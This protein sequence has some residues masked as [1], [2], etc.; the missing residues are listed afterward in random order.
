MVLSELAANAAVEALAGR[1]DGGSLRL[2]AGPQPAAPEDEPPG[3]LLAELRFAV[4]AFGPARSG[5]VTAHALAPERDA[6]AA[7]VA[8]WFRCLTASG[9]AVLDGTA[10]AEG[11]EELVLGTAEIAR[12]AEVYVDDFSLSIYGR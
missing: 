4:R 6:P 8:R 3:A 7:G 11:T 12:G 1:L 5:R 9:R 2:Y 10:G